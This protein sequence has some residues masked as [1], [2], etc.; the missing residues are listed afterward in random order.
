MPL[1]SIIIP[2]YNSERFVEK[3]IKSALQQTFQDFEL[4][5]VDDCSTD[6]TVK[7]IEAI[8]DGDRRIKIFTHT[9]NVG[10]AANRNR[11]IAKASGQYVAFLDHDDLW[12]SEKLA[13]QLT[14]LEQSPRAAVAYSWIDLI[15]EDG[16]YLRQHLRPRYTGYIYKNL[17]VTNFLVTASNP[18]IRMNC[19][20][21]IGEFDETIYGSDDWELLTRLAKNYEFILVKECHIK[22]R[23]FRGSG[24]YNFR[25]FEEGKLRAV[26]KVFSQTDESLKPLKR[27]ALGSFY[28]YLSFKS[29]DY[30]TSRRDAFIS[31]R[32]MIFSMYYDLKQWIYSDRLAKILFKSLLIVVFP[33]PIAKKIINFSVRKYRG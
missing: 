28:L 18:L 21:S 13:M 7:V 24:T 6:N 33:I 3:T 22:Y 2:T 1:I 10:I 26:T 12:L 8:A 14:A 4:I 17:L 19:L 15:D 25:K 16:Q 11:G 31:M 27:Q 30:F 5:I 20:K 23:V 29:L 32:Y 9:T